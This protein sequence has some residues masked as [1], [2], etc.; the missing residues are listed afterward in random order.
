MKIEDEAGKPNKETSN[1]GEYSSEQLD[2]MLE[3]YVAA[4][5]IEQDPEKMSM[6]KQY[7]QSKQK[8]VAGLFDGAQT[9]KPKS[10]KDLKKIY[11]DKLAKER[12]GES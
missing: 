4:K 8:E 11:S 10:L 3:T 1:A 7:A 6:L 12:E 5:R 9:E 2:E